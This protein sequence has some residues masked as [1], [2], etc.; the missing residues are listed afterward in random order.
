MV[1]RE[2]YHNPYLMA[3]WDALFYGADSRPLSRGKVVEALL[4]Y[5]AARLQDGSNV[6][7]IARHVLGLFQGQK[8][9]RQWRRMLSDSKELHG[10]DESLF[11]RALLATQG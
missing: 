9:A 1:G 3:E 11:I 10:A 4:P 8:G 6:R 2:A 5:V 7:H